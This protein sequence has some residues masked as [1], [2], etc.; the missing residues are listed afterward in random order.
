MSVGGPGASDGRPL[1]LN[2]TR[3]ARGLE[4]EIRLVVNATRDG[5][6][7]DH[8]DW[9]DARFDAGSAPSGASQGARLLS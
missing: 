7:G 2:G 6:N 4:T 8:A 3:F 1:T 9:A 5:N